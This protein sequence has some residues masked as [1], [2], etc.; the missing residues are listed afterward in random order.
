MCRYSYGA[1]MWT[2][3]DF[4]VP[5]PTEGIKILECV[6]VMEMTLPMVVATL[7]KSAPSHTVSLTPSSSRFWM[8]LNLDGTQGQ[9]SFYFPVK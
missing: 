7:P 2:Y 4:P 1:S 8:H 6:Q 5:T 9:F 3:H